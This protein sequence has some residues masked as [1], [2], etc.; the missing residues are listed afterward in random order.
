MDLVGGFFQLL[1][2][3]TLALAAMGLFAF[4]DSMIR[5]ASAYVAAGKLTK[6]AWAAIVGLSTVVL[7][8]VGALSLFGL[9]AIVAVIVYLVDVRPALRGL[10]SG[11]G[12]RSSGSS[13]N[14]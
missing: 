6:L 4:I 5:P 8:Y 2:L 3:L 12:G 1:N 14:W 11:G 9:P 13:S 10:T 7:L